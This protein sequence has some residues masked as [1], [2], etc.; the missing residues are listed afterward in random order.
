MIDGRLEM[1]L[2]QKLHER[3]ES[4]SETELEWLNTML[5]NNEYPDIRVKRSP[6]ELTEIKSLLQELAA[7]M[8]AEETTV[9]NKAMQS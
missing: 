2:K 4:L 3:I 7:P 5:E 6:E 9:F 1:T 8:T